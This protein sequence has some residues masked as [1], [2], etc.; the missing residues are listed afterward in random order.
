[1]ALAVQTPAHLHSVGLL[2]NVSDSEH[3]D[4]N[5]LLKSALDKVNISSLSSVI[6]VSNMF[7]YSRW[8]FCLLV[9]QSTSSVGDFLM[10]KLTR[11]R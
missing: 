1:M 6:S 8:P 2:P 9:T 3:A 10:A 11:K 7:F 4:I 5:Y